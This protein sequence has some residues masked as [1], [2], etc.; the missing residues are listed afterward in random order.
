MTSILTASGLLFLGLSVFGSFK[1][2]E[3]TESN[4]FCGTVCHTVMSPEHTAYQ[5]SPHARPMVSGLE[6]HGQRKDGTV[7]RAEIA[8]NPV[9]TSEGL[10]VTSTIRRIDEAD[11]SEAYF[12]MLL[13][14][15]PDAMIIID[16]QGKI[17]IAKYGRSWRGI[18]PKLA[19]EN[20]AIAHAEVRIDDSVLM[21]GDRPKGMEPVP[22][23]VHVYVAD[24]DAAHARAVEKGAENVQDPVKRE[25]ADRRG[26]S[27]GR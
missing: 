20:G 4:E 23:H 6:L 7:F 14:S 22:A 26:G 1:A 17:A 21:L 12:R 25:D 9:E 16:E 13:E 3:Y 18:K 5:A 19:G 10:V 27:R 8:L 15:A 24:V 2:Y 11:I